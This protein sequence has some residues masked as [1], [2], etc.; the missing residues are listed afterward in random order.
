MHVYLLILRP[1]LLSPFPSSIL[2]GKKF[3]DHEVVVTACEEMLSA[4]IRSPYLLALLVDIYEE[5]GEEEKRKEA[6][7]VG[8]SLLVFLISPSSS[9]SSS[10]YTPGLGAG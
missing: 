8:D 2:R 6:V 5:S 9:S 3:R 1:L 10:W 7:K 4:H